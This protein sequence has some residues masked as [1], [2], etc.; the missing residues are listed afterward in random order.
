MF[1]KKIKIFIFYFFSFLTYIYSDFKSKKN[2][3]E[4]KLDE[5]SREIKVEF[6]GQNQS[7]F[8][9]KCA[10]IFYNMMI[11]TQDHQFSLRQNSPFEK[12]YL[13]KI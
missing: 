13:V 10:L 6:N 11:T 9:G 3:E 5:L 8:R 12:F 7:S 4:F 1:I 2:F